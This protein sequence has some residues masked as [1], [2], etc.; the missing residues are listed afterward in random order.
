MIRWVTVKKFAD[1]SGYS[2]AAV[3]RKIQDRK[4]PAAV[5]I[6]A[7][8]G[9]ILINIEEYEKWVESAREA[10]ALIRDISRRASPTPVPSPR[11]WRRPK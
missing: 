4:W 5:W 11:S 8:D 9:H 3:R 10:P 1:E 2:E 6:K 7:L